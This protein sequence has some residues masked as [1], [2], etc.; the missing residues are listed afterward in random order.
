MRLAMKLGVSLRADHALA[1]RGGQERLER[2]EQRRVGLR[3]GDQLDQVHVAR[4][5]EEV[6][7]AEARAQRR[8]HRR[9][10]RRERQS[11]RVGR[12]DRVRRDVRRDLLV[13][14][15]LPVEA[16]GD[17]LD[18]EIAFGEAREVAR[19]SWRPRSRRRGPWPPSGA[20]SSLARPAIAL[21][22]RPFGI[23]LL[24][25]AGRT[26]ATGMPALAKC[27]AICAPMTP[28]PSTA[29]LRMSK[30]MEASTVGP[31]ADSGCWTAVRPKNCAAGMPAAR[32]RR[33]KAKSAPPVGAAKL[34]RR[35]SAAF[36][37]RL[38]CA[39][40]CR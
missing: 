26:A 35:R 29:A 3:R 23:A 39:R 8:G 38:P 17:R 11:R 40:T 36:A 7:A 10:Q 13:Q 9:R 16:L 21:V 2:V 25:R 32:R 20:G 4:R 6:D 18:H 1:E 12:E 27:A 5:I 24:R 22:T 34:G 19:R 15:A 33:R 30:R 37:D 31:A 28:A 14:V